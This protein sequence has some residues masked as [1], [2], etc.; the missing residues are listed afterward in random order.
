MGFL[1]QHPEGVEGLLDELHDFAK[2]LSL[3]AAGQRMLYL[4]THGD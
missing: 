2:R 3:G 1:C 4:L